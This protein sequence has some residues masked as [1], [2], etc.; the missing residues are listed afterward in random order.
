M[1][2]RD[3]ACARQ[4]TWLALP[5]LALPLLTLPL[6]VWSMPMGSTPALLIPV[7][8]ITAAGREEVP[9]VIVEPSAASRRE[10]Q[11]VVS[12]ALRPAAPAP[13]DRTMQPSPPDRDGGSARP[14]PVALAD[15]ALTTTNLLAITHA[16][17]RD[18]A[19]HPANGRELTHPE[20][21]ELFKHGSRCVLVRSKTGQSWTLRHTRCK[22]MDRPS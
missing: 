16:N 7:S 20:T 9:A 19:G 8:S 11:R 12:T 5:A 22:A 3:A 10:L 13:A 18:S 21:F 17:P 2:R 14:R 6:P 4:V 1:P 15:D